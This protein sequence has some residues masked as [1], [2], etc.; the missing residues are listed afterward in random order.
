MNSVQTKQESL[1]V[2]TKKASKT[3]AFWT[4]LWVLST[5]VM[6]FGPKLVW[7]FNLLFSGLAVTVNLLFGAKMLLVN[8]KYLQGLDE[9]QR[10]IQLN[11]MAL[12]LG[13]GL[14]VGLAYDILEDIR[15]I[16]FEPSIAHLVILM[17]LVHLISVLIAT[18]K[19]Q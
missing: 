5:A 3:L 10:D 14:V 7:D 18:R 16:A 6:A 11:S 15:M 2:R 12:T 8:R 17:S 4:F 19:Y 13:V 9:M 1:T